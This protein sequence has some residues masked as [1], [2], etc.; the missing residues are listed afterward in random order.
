M[1]A[2]I[3]SPSDPS[4]DA[5][6]ARGHRN[7]AGWLKKNPAMLAMILDTMIEGNCLTAFERGFISRIATA[8]QAGGV[9]H[10]EL[11]RNYLERCIMYGHPNNEDDIESIAATACRG[12][13]C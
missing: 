13:L 4:Q 5:D 3:T 2:N 9:A 10:E 7:A 11:I 1:T 6:Y 12:A 8:A